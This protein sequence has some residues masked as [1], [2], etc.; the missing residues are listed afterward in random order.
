MNVEFHFSGH[1]E[2]FKS[3]VCVQC[4]CDVSLSKVILYLEYT[5]WSKVYGRLSMVLLQIGKHRIECIKCVQKLSAVCF[6]FLSRQV[7]VTN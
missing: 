7:G 5:T 4:L 2:C 3:S 6:F 1:S